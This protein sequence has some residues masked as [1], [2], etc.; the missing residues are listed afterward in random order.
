MDYGMPSLEALQV[1]LVL[2][3]GFVTY[4]VESSLAY[5]REHSP[6]VMVARS[7]VYSLLVYALCSLLAGAPWLFGASG[8]AS[9]REGAANIY[10][11]AWGV[12]FVLFVAV[13]AGLVIGAAKTHDWHMRVGRRVGLTR[14]TSRQGIWLDIMQDLYARQDRNGAWVVVGLK[15]GRRIN[16]WPEHFSDE[17]NEGPTLFLTHAQWL[18]ERY[19][20]ERCVS[21]PDPG[22]LVLG[23]QIRF[24]QFYAPEK[25]EKNEQEVNDSQDSKNGQAV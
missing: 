25:E 6:T 3:P 16:G 19:G 8:N 17:Y 15:D 1:M 21:I 18:S 12:L 5:Q 2:L 14:R 7:L 9:Q 10:V 20:Q 4:F 23:S 11:T 22:I 24:V 13:A